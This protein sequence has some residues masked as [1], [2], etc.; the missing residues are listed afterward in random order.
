MIKLPTEEAVRKHLID[1]YRHVALY[2]SLTRRLIV[3]GELAPEVEEHLHDIDPSEIGNKLELDQNNP[4][5]KPQTEP[6][7]PG[8]LFLM[9]LGY[10]HPT[11]YQGAV[12]EGVTRHNENHRHHIMFNGKIDEASEQ[13]LKLSSLDAV[14]SWIENRIYDPIK[15]RD[16]EGIEHRIKSNKGKQRKS[17]D[18]IYRLIRPLE[19]P[20]DLTQVGDLNHLPRL[21]MCPETHERVTQLFN[22][23]VRELRTN[24]AYTHSYIGLNMCR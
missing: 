23:T 1:T 2:H 19:A 20:P 5:G 15:T 22:E 17:L 14:C 3:A 7:V 16:W 8:V 12:Q 18:A 4:L 21:D 13:D 11:C 9:S 10:D 24:G 6:F